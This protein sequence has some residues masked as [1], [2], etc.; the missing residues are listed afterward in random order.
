MHHGMLTPR[1]LG[2]L[3]AA[4]CLTLCLAPAAA[5]ARGSCAPRQVRPRLLHHVAPPQSF[6]SSLSVLRRP[7]TPADLQGSDTNGFGENELLKGDGIVD[8]PGIE[9]PPLATPSFIYADYIRKLGSVGGEPEYVVPARVQTVAPMS[10]RCLRRLSAKARRQ[11]LKLERADRARGVVFLFGNSLFLLS[12]ETYSELIGYPPFLV[13]GGEPPVIPGEPPVVKAPAS[14]H[15]DV[16][17]GIVPDG[18]AS[19]ALLS[20]D[21]PEITVQVTANFFVIEV[22]S[23]FHHGG[24]TVVWRDASGRTLKSLPG[25]IL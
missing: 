5:G 12:I 10:R 8:V 25:A 21:N 18:V 3:T 23:S 20:E 9:I 16:V 14:P 2:A 19:V 4:A 1:H 15:P 6:L 22:P 24:A 17:Y 11:Q 7:Q 13:T